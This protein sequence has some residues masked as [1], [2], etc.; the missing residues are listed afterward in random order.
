[1][2]AR[3]ITTLILGILLCE[4]CLVRRVAEAA[5][6]PKVYQPSAAEI[7]QAQR[8]V[9]GAL[10]RLQGTGGKVQPITPEPVI[11]TFPTYVFFSV[12]FRQGP[13]VRDL[14]A[15]LQSGNVYAVPR[16]KDGPLHLLTDTRGLEAFFRAT[17]GPIQDDDT[18]KDVARTWLYLAPVISQDGFYQFVLQEDSLKIIAKTPGR[19]VSG[20]VVVMAGGN[21]E[22][23]ATLTFDQAG[24]L[25]NVAQTGNLKP[26]IRPI[27][28]ATKLLDADPLVRRMAEQD[29]LILGRAAQE[30]LAAQRARAS[31]ALQWAIDQLWQRI[32]EEGR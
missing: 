29:L 28:Q 20:K 23:A 18:A 24:K 31:P 19:Q 13:V 17:L 4:P 2:W 5:D 27:C 1:M 15:P 22:I 12:V 7:E 30:Y 25:V 10:A 16:D 6:Q 14:P 21:G 9:E 8:H 32:V 3:L 11:K 26:S